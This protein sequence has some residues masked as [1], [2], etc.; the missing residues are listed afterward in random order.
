MALS[1][2][3]ISF[4]FIF[5]AIKTF[6]VVQRIGK[7]AG[8]QTPKAPRAGQKAGQAADHAAHANP[9][10]VKINIEDVDKDKKEV[11]HT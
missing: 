6:F 11:S 5:S 2:I 10:A 7:S 1:S 3:V 9:E 4:F 8:L